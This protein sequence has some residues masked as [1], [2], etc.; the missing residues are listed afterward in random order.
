MNNASV[1]RVLKSF[2][3]LHDD[4]TGHRPLDRAEQGDQFVQADAADE[5]HHQKMHRSGVVDSIGSNDVRVIELHAGSTFQLHSSQHAGIQ[6]VLGRHDFD[7][8]L[9][10]FFRVFG[11]EDAT[12]AAESEQFTNAIAIDHKTAISPFEESL[13]LKRRENSFFDEPLGCRFGCGVGIQFQFRLDLAHLGR[14]QQT[15]LF[16]QLQEVLRCDGNLHI[17]QL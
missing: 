1:V 9:A 14:C 13:G 4:V 3:S 10:I 12:H 5:F 7:G 16:D 11:D 17:Q 15:A 6:S 2:G 8:D